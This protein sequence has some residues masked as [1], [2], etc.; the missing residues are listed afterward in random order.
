MSVILILDLCSTIMMLLRNKRCSNAEDDYYPLINHDFF[1]KDD[2]NRETMD[3]N[4]ILDQLKCAI[5]MENPDGGEPKP[6]N[7]RFDDWYWDDEQRAQSVINY[8]YKYVATTPKPNNKDFFKKTGKLFGAILKFLERNR[9]IAKQFIQSNQQARSF[10][11]SMSN[12][13]RDM[14][15]QR[16]EFPNY[17]I[18]L[19]TSLGYFTNVQEEN[20]IKRITESMFR[21]QS[22]ANRDAYKVTNDYIY[23]KQLIQD[24]HAME[25]LPPRKRFRRG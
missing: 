21:K 8:Y 23:I 22:I 2:T 1:V 6:R 14:I 3:T 7:G 5:D 4:K 16:R 13:E 9:I 24:Q 17:R 10:H 25:M 19:F 11:S 15:M 18:S 20:L 12:E